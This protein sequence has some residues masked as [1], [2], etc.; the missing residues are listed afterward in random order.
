MTLKLESRMFKQCIIPVLIYGWQSWTTLKQILGKLLKHKGPW[1]GKWLAHPEM[2]EREI[3]G[4]IPDSWQYAGIQ[5]G[6]YR[7]S[8]KNLYWKKNR[9][10]T[11]WNRPLGTQTELLQQFFYNT[12][13]IRKLIFLSVTIHQ[14]YFGMLRKPY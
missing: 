8:I 4:M 7:L 1:K 14:H 6:Q 11:T 2:T 3:N 5:N 13:K 12:A 10:R 9:W